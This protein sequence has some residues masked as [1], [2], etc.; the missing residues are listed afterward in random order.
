MGGVLVIW[1]VGSGLSVAPIRCIVNMSRSYLYFPFHLKKFV[2]SSLR[3]IFVLMLHVSFQTLSLWKW[4]KIQ[5]FNLLAFNHITPSLMPTLIRV[6]THNCCIYSIGNCVVQKFP[7]KQEHWVLR[8]P[9]TAIT[10]YGF[11]SFRSAGALGEGCGR[12]NR[13]LQN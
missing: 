8:Q 9:G 2:K 10:H 4:L 5:E 6:T 3:C 13:L 1:K 12:E 11:A 7:E